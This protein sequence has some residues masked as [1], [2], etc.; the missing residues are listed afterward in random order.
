M[1]RLREA[2]AWWRWGLLPWLLLWGALG[3]AAQ[4]AE[5]AQPVPLLPVQ[6]GA[7][8]GLWPGQLSN[9]SPAKPLTSD[10][11]ADFRIAE[12]MVVPA[13]TKVTVKAGVT[14]TLAW[15]VNLTVQ[16]HLILAGTQDKV[17]QVVGEVK[18]TGPKKPA[19]GAGRLL[20]ANRGRLTLAH[21]RL[22]QLGSGRAGGAVELVG[23]G[24]ELAL[25][26]VEFLNISGSA[27]VGRRGR[28]SKFDGVAFKGV[29]GNGLELYGDRVGNVEVQ[30][31]TFQDCKGHGILTHRYQGRLAV[32]DSS[33]SGGGRYAVFVDG[34]M[35]FHVDRNTFT[36]NQGAFACRRHELADRSP[37]AKEPTLANNTMTDNQVDTQS[38]DWS[39][40]NLIYLHG[41][42]VR[43]TGNT[44]LRTSKKGIP[45]KESKKL[46]NLI[47][48]FDSAV[49]MRR[50]VVVNNSRF[51]FTLN[52]GGQKTKL[53]MEQNLL[54]NSMP[55]LKNYEVANEASGV[56]I[57][58]KR[59]WWGAETEDEA[60]DRILDFVA[61]GEK[62]GVVDYQP[63][64][65]EPDMDLSPPDPAEYVDYDGSWA[66]G[67]ELGSKTLIEGT[68]T[69]DGSQPVLNNTWVQKDARLIISS[70]Y[71]D[72]PG[73]V[74]ILLGPGVSLHVAGTLQVPGTD[75]SF[76][77]FAPMEGEDGSVKPWGS[78]V[79]SESAKATTDAG[80]AG[81]LRF[82]EFVG[83]GRPMG[84]DGPAKAGAGGMVVLA[85]PDLVIRDSVFEGSAG[86]GLVVAK[87]QPQVDHC[88]FTANEG[89][90]VASHTT[91]HVTVKRSTFSRNRKFPILVT[92]GTYNVTDNTFRTGNVGVM[93]VRR[94]RNEDP[95]KVALE[96]AAL[97]VSDFSRNVLRDNA[98]APGPDCW[99][100]TGED[101]MLLLTLAAKPVV[102]SEN[103][104]ADNK[105]DSKAVRRRATLF[106]LTAEDV[107]HLTAN[108]VQGNY[109]KVYVARPLEAVESWEHPPPAF[110]FEGNVF[111]RNLFFSV[112][113]NL[114][115][116]RG[117]IRDN[118][119]QGNEVDDESSLKAQPLL[120]VL[121]GEF[122]RRPLTLTNNRLLDNEGT[123]LALR[124]HDAAVASGNAF[125]NPL[126]KYELEFANPD[127]T[128]FTGTGNYW[129][130]FGPNDGMDVAQRIKPSAS[131]TVPKRWYH[132]WITNDGR[133]AGAPMATS[134]KVRDVDK[135]SATLTFLVV[136][137]LGC[138]I[139]VV[140]VAALY[141]RGA[142]HY[143]SVLDLDDE[144]PALD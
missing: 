30:R 15:D 77:R 75:T 124:L 52:V 7:G 135:A 11:D 14:L 26:A 104:V 6:P 12:D 86:A 47:N 103:V 96:R 136:L 20:L 63:I 126:I 23:K 50:N 94:R 74:T 98:Y 59:N 4:P 43:V 29:Q 92:H 34:D 24:S 55:G 69:W 81:V 21:A 35:E 61:G 48:F 85:G 65:T 139:V 80:P 138:L 27:V 78:I 133:L 62:Y 56:R 51:L 16:G 60:K 83:G 70:A 121:G 111:A 90:A 9:L 17:I 38:D 106:L 134:D 57:E 115:G 49:E 112:M 46:P 109:G 99:G 22:R 88:Q 25:T 71:S 140:V 73:N 102:V 41:C 33:F 44:I 142:G 131:R 18:S 89:N 125:S 114:P 2:V 105:V 67:M 123:L 122:T 84:R 66:E 58:A 76:V 93:C 108:N 130:D 119:L 64:L 117:F 144:R 110:F 37:N 28:I 19:A 137:V 1:A 97:P 10:I 32:T 95:T 129:G 8:A 143:A 79:F 100:D 5:L 91:K 127:L 118:L 68:V 87:G 36:N 82:V 39:Q 53:I 45:P 13:E 128:G 31:S 120:D 42:T 101:A 116:R 3:A 54:A 72:S 132:N 40:G 113:L 141:C 107:L